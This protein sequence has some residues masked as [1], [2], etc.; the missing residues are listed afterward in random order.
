MSRSNTAFLL[1][2][3]VKLELSNCISIHP[4]YN[5]GISLIEA[6]IHEFIKE[7][8]AVN[9]IR[10]VHL[11]GFFGPAHHGRRPIMKILTVF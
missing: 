5:N 6:A 9:Y 10:T 3:R 11:W 8:I 7:L 2:G 1:F 4:K